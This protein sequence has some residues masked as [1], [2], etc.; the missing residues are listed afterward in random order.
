MKTKTMMAIG[1]NENVYVFNAVGIDSLIVLEKE[2]ENI[3]NV[4]T[5]EGIKIFFVSQQFSGKINEIRKEY[6]SSYPIFLTLAM[7]ENVLS[8][9]VKE[10]EENVEKATGIKLF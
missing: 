2:L 7:D 9:G 8:T 1:H 5:Q 10:L 6:Q 3:I 4:K